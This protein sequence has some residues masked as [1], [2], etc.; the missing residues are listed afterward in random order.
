MLLWKRLQTIIQHT[1]AVL[2]L[3]RLTVTLIRGLGL[4]ATFDGVANG[5]GFGAV[6]APFEEMFD[7]W[8]T[9][10]VMEWFVRQLKA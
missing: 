7:E 1:L 2:V 10:P 6:V 9:I 3:L 5:F 4:V 8:I